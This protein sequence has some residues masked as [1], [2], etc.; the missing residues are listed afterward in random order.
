MTCFFGA[1]TAFIMFYL[2]LW[3]HDEVHCA[4]VE[5]IP[6]TKCATV[7]TTVKLTW[8]VKLG[9]SEGII[10]IKLHKLP[11]DEN[12]I[13]TYASQKLTVN[14]KGRQ[15]FGKRLSANYS[16]HYENVTLT[17]QNIKYNENVTFYFV[18]R[19]FPGFVLGTGVIT[20]KC[21]TGPPNVCGK[22][23]KS[24]YYITDTATITVAQDIC[25]HPKPFVEWKLE[26]TSF[27]SSSR[28]MLIDDAT[29][30]YRYSFTTENIVRS[31]CGEKIMYHAR[32]EFGNVEGYAMI[33]ISFTPS[34]VRITS[35]YRH[36][37]SCVY[38]HWYREDTG[39]CL[40]EYHIQFNNINDVYNTSK[41]NVD[42]CHS[43]SAS[44]ASIWASY[45]GNTGG[46][47]DIILHL[48]TLRPD[49]TILSSV[50]TTSKDDWHCASISAIG[51]LTTIVIGLII[52]IVLFV[53]LGRKGYLVFKKSSNTTL[54]HMKRRDDNNHEVIGT[55]SSHYPDQNVKYVKPCTNADLTKTTDSSKG[56][57]E[58]EFS[59]TKRSMHANIST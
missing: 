31:K 24:R 39:N 12:N 23:V 45:K 2:I 30:K 37:A 19:F 25:G 41:T 26:D 10:Y 46:K 50:T 56:Y 13:V 5:P 48:I 22:S 44:S 9:P 54:Q 51:I 49:I 4:S 35:S 53:T 16:K 14:I 29:K 47:V 38:L 55:T 18:A 15:L 40:L 20:I 27:S 1:S 59:E 33:Y 3:K 58:I 17:L 32:T 21:V 7:N 28:S 42:I 52:N 34:K 57:A 8:K 11:D 6:M 36:N 43:P